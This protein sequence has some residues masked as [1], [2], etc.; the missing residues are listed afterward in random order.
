MSQPTPPGYRSRAPVHTHV[1]KA[2]SSSRGRVGAWRAA[3]WVGAGRRAHAHGSC[4]RALHD[5]SWGGDL[6]V[7]TSAV[8]GEIG[9]CPPTSGGANE[10]LVRSGA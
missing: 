8:V 1:A 7:D 2:P 5:G 4:R 10:Q 6:H 9:Q 3:G